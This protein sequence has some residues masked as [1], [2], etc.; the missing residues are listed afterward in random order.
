MEK[1]RPIERDHRRD[2][3][4][5]P[6]GP[7]ERTELPAPRGDI[8]E[9]RPF[10]PA[11]ARAPSSP[12]NTVPFTSKG[13]GIVSSKPPP[14]P[15]P[16]GADSGEAE[17]ALRRQLSRLQRQ[18]AEAQRELAHKDE[19][20]TSELERRLGA[21]AA[22]DAL[23]LEHREN[24]GRL[25]E[26]ET[27]QLRAAGIEQRLQDSL[28]NIEELAHSLER[29]RRE[30]IAFGERVLELELALGEQREGQARKQHEMDQRFASEVEILESQNRSA[31]AGMEES[32]Q[33]ALARLSKTHEAEA[34]AQL[35]AH[36]RAVGV[37][38]GELEPQAREAQ[39]LAA[40]RER[41]I[42][43]LEAVRRESE[44]RE[45]EMAEM[46]VRDARQLALT[47]DEE[48]A[49]LF[50]AHAAELS[51]EID[52][53]EDQKRALMEANRAVERR[54][55]SLQQSLDALRETMKQLQIEL[56][57]VREQ[58]TQLETEKASLE[59][60]VGELQRLRDA[61]A[62]EKQGLVERLEA[63]ERDARRNAFDRSRFIAYLEEG[64]AL[65]G[66][67]PPSELPKALVAPSSAPALPPEGA[68][69]TAPVMPVAAA[70]EAAQ[71][72]QA[73]EECGAPAA[74]G[75]DSAEP[76]PP[77]KVSSLP[78]KAAKA[79]SLPPKAASSPPK[80]APSSPRF[81]GVPRPTP[82]GQAPKK[83]ALGKSD[84]E[85]LDPADLVAAEP[86]PPP[87]N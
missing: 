51:R 6:P 11:P 71:A 59:V 1:K 66:G 35:Q 19:E 33:E 25:Q 17:L 63:V 39:T 26:V 32:H 23:L 43:E 30:R 8:R 67:L 28:T 41:L 65:L 27:Q 61:E 7:R 42:G 49:S 87:R 81:G 38:R 70:A 12:R 31:L 83:D 29:E 58:V 80:G 86:G 2:P 4:E 56:A 72:A 21:F 37:L 78:P 52:K 5:P 76:P 44:R 74:K 62:S 54:E 18:L 14:P 16:Q 79:S 34:A 40:D 45:N 15:Q 48:K 53:R 9:D 60:R 64:L 69:A 75:D 47:H 50:R 36:E 22:Y 77:P 68:E 57:R 84:I 82:K 20:L 3:S 24:L 10:E 46:R 13:M 85:E 55:A 73:A